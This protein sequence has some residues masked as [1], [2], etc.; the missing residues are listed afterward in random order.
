MK[1]FEREWPEDP[2][3]KALTIVPEL[4]A[5]NNMVRVFVALAPKNQ[6]M[7]TDCIWGTIL[8]PMVYPL[9]GWGRGLAPESAED[10]SFSL[11]FTG[12][13][14][15][16]IKDKHT[17]ATTKTERWLRSSDAY[18]LVTDRWLEMLTKVD[19]GLGCGYPRS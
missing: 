7:C 17:E 1:V 3:E 19:P 15:A 13:D 18:D 14:F 5:I 12:E 2:F 16:N 9:L 8:K 11:M 10:M 6:P 4:R